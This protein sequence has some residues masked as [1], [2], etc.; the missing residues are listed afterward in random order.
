M[1]DVMAYPGGKNGAGVYQT[2]INLMPPHE[3]YIEPFLGGGAIM[4]LKR[5]ALESFGLDLSPG[6]IAEFGAARS[7]I[8]NGDAAGSR[9]RK[10]EGIHSPQTAIRDRLSPKLTTSADTVTRSDARRRPSSDLT[11][12]DPQ[13]PSLTLRA[14]CGISF[15]ENYRFTGRELVYCDPPYLMETRSGGRLYDFEMSTL[16]H[17]RLLRCIRKIPAKVMI[18]G[19]WSRMYAE[20]LKGWTLIQFQAMTRGGVAVE[21][22]WMNFAEPVALHDYRFL[23]TNFRERERIKRKKLRWTRKLSAMPLLERRALLAAI[24][25]THGFSD[26]VLS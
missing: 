12:T 19:Y 20:A 8:A 3:T 15:L 1:L 23:G 2:I 11:R 6:A 18:S 21:S 22:L 16:Q 5:P 14:A 17:R 9:A 4:R 25:S 7:T 10:G 26:G 24:A 13:S